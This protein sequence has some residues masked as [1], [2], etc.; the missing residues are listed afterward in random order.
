M[1]GADRFIRLPTELLE[2]LLQVRLSGMQWRILSWVIRQ[3]YGWNRNTAPFSW[4]RIATDL[5]SNRGG[6][7]RAG[8]RLLGCGILNSEANQI[9]ILEN[10]TQWGA[11]RLTP[12]GGCRPASVTNDMQKR[13]QKLLRPLNAAVLAD[14]NA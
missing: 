5:A 3:T 9:G 12:Q 7:V 6:V 10:R 4:Y 11:A 13:C 14:P 1:P 2:S 8:N